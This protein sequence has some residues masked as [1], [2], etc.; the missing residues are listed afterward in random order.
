MR[1]GGGVQKPKFLQIQP[2]CPLS[3]FAS[4][5]SSLLEQQYDA[6]VVKVDADE[7]LLKSLDRGIRV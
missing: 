6:E 1:G 5:C 2:Q 4:C 3:Q 7:K